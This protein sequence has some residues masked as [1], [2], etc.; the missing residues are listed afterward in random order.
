MNN[1]QIQAVIESFPRQQFPGLET[2]GVGNKTTAGVTSS[3]TTVVFGVKQ[4]KSKNDL[5]EEQILPN[6]IQTEHGSIQTDV[7]EDTLEWE[8]EL[9]CPD[10]TSEQIDEHRM[11]HRPII[12]GVSVGTGSENNKFRVGTLGVL[13]IDQTDGQVVGL[14]NN[15][16]LTPDVFSLAADQRQSIGYKDVDIYQPS[17]AETGGQAIAEHKIGH[18]KRVY[19]I[20]STGV[21]EIDAGLISIDPEALVDQTSGR[22]LNLLD[23]TGQGNVLSI[24]FATPLEI[25]LL[26]KNRTPLFKSSRTTGAIGNHFSPEQSKARNRCS[27]QVELMNYTP[28]VTGRSFTNI[29]RYFDPNDTDKI[30]PSAGGDS[31]SLICGWIKDQWKAVGLHFAGSRNSGV[32]YGLMCRMD[33][34]AE[35][36]NIAQFDPEN[37]DIA[38]TPTYRVISGYSDQMYVEI[39]GVTYWQIARTTDPVT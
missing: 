9:D 20:S 31:G 8:F 26:Q 10:M 38:T 15:H 34:V 36:L 13:V 4:K 14:T 12:G 16:V 19:P 2:L 7:V 6:T 33:R 28:R 17:R 21:N 27:L 24:P 37:V 5:P 3:E 18:V 23:D 25:D 11:K 32:D 22:V 35:L 1:Q 30:D 39:D 29:M